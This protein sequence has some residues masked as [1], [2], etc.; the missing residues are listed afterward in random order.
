[1]ETLDENSLLA[2]A[3]RLNVTEDEKGSYTWYT[4][5]RH[6]C[7]NLLEVSVLEMCNMSKSEIHQ[8][9]KMMYIKYWRHTIDKGEGVGKMHLYNR[10]KQNFD[11]EDYLNEV[12]N[13]QYR[14]AYTQLRISA[15]RLEV[16]RGRYLKIPRQSRFCKMCTNG[17]GDEIHFLTNCAA[18]NNERHDL[19][20]DIKSNC[21]NFET[22]DNLNKA[23]YMLTAGGEALKAVAKFCYGGFEQYSSH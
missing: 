20:L 15:H 17:I 10:I 14:K 18:L 11:F 8:R 6:I 7:Q 4:G 12:R 2:L 22:L 1:M 23:H 5:V 19:F 21:K 3:Y 16:E 9:L 13:P